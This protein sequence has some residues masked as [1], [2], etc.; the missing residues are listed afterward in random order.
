MSRF[1]VVTTELYPETPGG[2]G[3]LVDAL[4]K[5]RAQQVGTRVLLLTPDPIQ[6]V[7]RPEVGTGVAHIPKS[8]FLERSRALAELL[9]PQVK[10]GDRVEIQDFEGIGFWAMS[11]RSELGLDKVVLTVR[12]HGPYDLLADAMDTVPDDWALPRAMEREVFAM[13]DQVLIPVEGHRVILRERYGVPTERIMLAPPPIP[14]ISKRA[15]RI[16]PHPVYAVLGRLGE[17][18]G[19]QDMVGAALALLDRG[20][21]ISVR[22]IGG[23]GWSPTAGL[24]MREWL[25]SM[26]GP[27]HRS[28]FQFVENRLRE[29]LPAELADV[30]AVVVPSR[31][32]SFCLAA[33]E[34]RRMGL[35]VVVPDI[36]AFRGLFGD[37][38]GALVY[39]GT[40]SG[41]T[42]SLGRLGHEQGLADELAARPVPDPGDPWAAY[43]TD[44]EPRHPRS[45]AGLGTGAM[46]RIEATSADLKPATGT[47]QRLYRLLPA[48]VAHAARRLAPKQ[49]KDRLR[50]SASWPVEEARRARQ[51]RLDEV[52]SRIAAGEFPE[53]PSP[54]VTVV[55]PVYNNARYLPESLAS[56]YEQ[57]H[58]SWEIVVV[59]DGSTEPECLAYLESLDRPRLRTI[60]QENRGLPGARN[61][62]IGEANGRFVIPLDSDDELS[63]DFMSRLLA[64]LE[65]RPQ[66]AYAHCHARLYHDV[67]AIWLTRPFNPYWQLLGNAVVG[68][69]LLRREAW[70]SVGGYD[71]TMTSGNEDWELWIRLMEHGWDQVLV[72]EVLFKY[73]KHGISMSVDTEAQFEDGRRSVRDRHPDLYSSEALRELKRK[74]YPLITVLGGFPELPEEVEAIPD[75]GELIRSWGKF[76]VD[77]RGVSDLPTESLFRLADALESDPDAESATTSGTPPLVMRR[78]WN[79]HDANAPASNVLHL[80]DPQTGSES[81]L[82]AHV[83]RG[84]WTVP[85][86]LADA[87]PVQRQAPQEDG[88]LPD[89]MKW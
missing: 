82:P 9:E 8:G 58:D 89:P 6:P 35:P 14:P 43:Q 27:E 70:E 13:A 65:D 79:L 20:E 19:S 18:K 78:R 31:F 44:P 62:G 38:T 74:W 68:C 41:L 12:F 86:D 11:H 5:G 88:R 42:G 57:S 25:E 4:V 80:E 1:L 28:S 72:P 2:A 54:D 51:N 64:V 61:A 52:E 66:A 56:V 7:H 53:T 77:L 63:P 76:V 49:L 71:E 21:R 23:D 32:E 34:A 26:I 47:V 16:P 60:R 39:D 29:D 85:I 59:D 15:R 55:I 83:P 3:V 73:R 22:F 67:D 24:G 36:A 69:V 33:H 81:V 87:V 75:E 84:G 40:V 50:S 45:Q 37:D 48:P 46:Q 17:M 30:T 10:P